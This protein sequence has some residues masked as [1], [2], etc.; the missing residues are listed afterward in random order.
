MTAG[1]SYERRTGQG[2]NADTGSRA[3]L[4]RL[5]KPVL[6]RPRLETRLDLGAPVTVVRGLPGAGKTILIAEWLK[7]QPSDRTVPVWLRGGDWTENQNSRLNQAAAGFEA[8]GLSLS[9]PGF[10]ANEDVEVVLVLDDLDAGGEPSEIGD[11]LEVVEKNRNLRLIVGARRRHPVEVTATRSVE[12]LA[13]GPDELALDVS[14]VVDLAHLMGTELT[15]DGA[16]TLV[17]AF[18]GWTAPIRLVIEAG[19]E[20]AGALRAADDYLRSAVVQAFADHQLP[21]TV[22]RFSLTERISRGIFRELADTAD[23][24]RHFGGLDASGLTQR[25]YED[26]GRALSLPT[27]TFPAAVGAAIQDL[28]TERHPE[29]AQKFHRRLARWSLDHDEP[30]NEV[31]AIH[32]AV[33]AHDWPTAEEVWFHHGTS[34][35]MQPVGTFE[36]ML[37]SIPGDV[38]ETYP[39]VAIYRRALDIANDDSDLDGRMA[40]VR[41]YFEASSQVMATLEQ[42]LLVELIVVCTGH[43]IG[44]R[45]LGRFDDSDQFA[46]EQ[47]ARIDRQIE[48]GGGR[49][50]VL[51]WFY[52]QW[53]LTRTLLGDR[54]GSLLRYRRCWEY[55]RTSKSDWVSSNTAANLAMTYA[56]SGDT[57]Q[58][59]HWLER[60]REFDTSHLWGDYLVGVG[61]HIAE[62]M[63]A[64]DRLDPTAVRPHL[65]HLGDGS[66][67]VE[68]WAFVAFLHAQYGLHFGNP[69]ATLASLDAAQ[70]SHDDSLSDKGMAARLLAR[71]RADLLIASGDPRRARQI[72]EESS[73]DQPMLAVPATRIHLLAGDDTTARRVAD[74]ALAR[75]GITTRDR[76]ELLLLQA[77]ALPAEEDALAGRMFLSA[78]GVYRATGIIRPFATLGT[79]VRGGLFALVDD[80]MAPAD[81]ARI[82]AQPAVYP[83]EGLSIRLSRQEQAVL[84]SL[85]HYAS[86]QDIANQMYVSVNTVKTHLNSVYRKLGTSTRDQ[87][88]SKARQLGLLP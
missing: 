29:E 81:R 51:R 62:G 40:T 25:R 76:L 24:D 59:D 19:T 49:P 88:L 16:E 27:L 11:L 35:M 3:E 7:Q 13:I 36:D 6:R 60:H 74:E 55:R 67:P 22:M 71:A 4:L 83:D 65:D 46:E 37:D 14:E 68:L 87:A 85:Q 75:P 45:L 17:Q 23:P 72:L 15:S 54:R 8:A 58:A 32:H 5:A 84:A 50:D 70:Q 64:L 47:G 79:A 80:A 30:G 34:L 44:L 66:I 31:A 41:S 86:R 9:V 12:T 21:E 52:L 56:L 61:A 48:A 28:Y 26:N 18:G 39:S 57:A 63:L 43:L 33:L 77:A 82:A 42:P 1:A 53:G 2:T 38:L 73:S 20:G 69:A 10:G 78:L